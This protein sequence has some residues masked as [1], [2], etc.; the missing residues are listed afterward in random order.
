MD[1]IRKLAFISVFLF[2]F[3]KRLYLKTKEGKEFPH[4]NVAL[5][6]DLKN[7]NKVKI[8]KKRT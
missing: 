2:K 3:I 7:P 1:L 8:Q 4:L 6:L 5:Y